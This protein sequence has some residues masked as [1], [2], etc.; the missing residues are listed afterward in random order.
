[1]VTHTGQGEQHDDRKQTKINIEVCKHLGVSY[2]NCI[3]Y[4]QK[5]VDSPIPMKC[6]GVHKCLAM[7]FVIIV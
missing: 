6:P 1:M 4:G 5:Y 2:I 7:Q 3:L